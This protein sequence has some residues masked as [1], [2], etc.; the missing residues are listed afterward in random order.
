MLAVTRYD[1]HME[2][3]GKA[4]R[5]CGELKP[6]SCY[7]KRSGTKDGLNTRCKE[8]RNKA[9]DASRDKDRDKYRQQCR[10]Y[11]AENQDQLV[12]ARRVSYQKHKEK[13]LPATL[14]YRQANPHVIWEGTFRG[15]CKKAGIAPVMESFTKDDLIATYGDRCVDCGGE[16]SQLEHVH[17]VSAGGPH[18][19]ENCRPIC[20]PCNKA[21]WHKFQ[22]TAVEFYTAHLLTNKAA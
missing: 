15:R 1:E 22:K 18:T 13:W 7:H 4:C 11:Y 2:K 3:T 20:P 16:G 17:P 14:A 6:L 9:S 19:L 10:N 21:R 8:C 12:E 5:G